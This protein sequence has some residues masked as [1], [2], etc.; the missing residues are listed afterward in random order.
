MQLREQKLELQK[1]IMG[2]EHPDTLQ[3][4]SDLGQDQKV[5]QLHEQTLELQ[6]RVFR[7]R[8]SQDD[9]VYERSGLDKEA[10]NEQTLEMRLIRKM[11]FM[12]RN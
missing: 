9:S 12:S 11:R 3:S 10:N 5:M 7:Y 1:R 4:M 2:N 6:K 8:A